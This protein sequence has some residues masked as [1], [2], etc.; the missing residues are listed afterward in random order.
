ML[1]TAAFKAEGFPFSTAPYSCAVH[2]KSIGC[3]ASVSQTKNSHKIGWGNTLSH[4]AGGDGWRQQ[5]CSC[6]LLQSLP[7]TF[8]FWPPTKAPDLPAAATWIIDESRIGTLTFTVESSEPT[9]K[10]MRH[11]GPQQMGLTLVHPFPVQVSRHSRLYC[12]DLCAP[13]LSELAA[14]T[15]TRATDT[16]PHPVWCKD[17]LLDH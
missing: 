4:Y 3:R 9:S 5:L 8:A 17:I 6:L 15:S 2:T 13:H 12:T 1:I 7:C 14:Q 11:P 16:G 10:P